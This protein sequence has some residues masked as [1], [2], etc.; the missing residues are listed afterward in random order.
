[1]KKI[2]ITLL[3]MLV[4]AAPAFAA[5]TFE[6]LL[7]DLGG[8]IMLEMVK[9]PAGTLQMGGDDNDPNKDPNGF[10]DNR[11][12]QG[13]IHAVTISKNFYMGKYEL[14]QGQ[15]TKIMGS[16]P[17]HFKN[18]DNYPVESVSWNDI[19]GKGAFLEKINS[20]TGRAFRLPTD[21]EWEYACRAGTKTTFYFGD[22]P[23]HKL[24]GNYAWYRDNSDKKTHPAGLK[25]PN[26][27]GLY[28]MSGNVREWCGDYYGKY[29]DRAVTDPSGPTTGTLRIFRGGGWCDPAWG[30][31]S[32][33][34]D[35]G[36]PSDRGVHIGFRLALHSDK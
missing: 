16:N 35:P 32:A 13:P 25:S 8:G 19:C 20:L 21:A 5:E 2:L 17:S 33:Y 9:I 3:L 4:F 26:A 30:C 10:D 23:S 7:I 28:D 11:A 36:A 27:F 14:T 18:G 1:M 29:A 15:W 31:R 12:S 34:R 24:I 6:N 22:D